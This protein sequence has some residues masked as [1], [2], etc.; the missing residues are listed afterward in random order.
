MLR[1]LTR[2]DKWNAS[3][4]RRPSLWVDWIGQLAS[5]RKNWIDVIPILHLFWS[6]AQALLPPHL[7]CLFSD[8]VHWYVLNSENCGCTCLF[9]EIRYSFLPGSVQKKILRLASWIILEMRFEERSCEAISVAPASSLL[10]RTYFFVRPSAPW[11]NLLVDRNHFSDR[12]HISWAWTSEYTQNTHEVIW[13][14]LVIFLGKSGS[15]VEGLTL[16]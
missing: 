8:C 7:L 1:S 11:S 15:K 5:E 4:Q 14:S 16:R 10:P 12:A 2:V 13:E 6:C 3:W 9:P